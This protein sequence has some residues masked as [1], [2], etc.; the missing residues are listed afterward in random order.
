MATDIWAPTDSNLQGYCLHCG[1]DVMDSFNKE[2][3]HI[4]NLILI[5]IMY[6]GIVFMK[7]IFI[8]DC[9]YLRKNESDGIE[10]L[11]E[12]IWLI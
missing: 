2:L 9:I 1:A 7:I 10:T 12:S 11:K 6:S 4:D 8:M 3:M 5:V